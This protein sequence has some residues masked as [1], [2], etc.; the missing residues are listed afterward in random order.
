MSIYITGDCH[1]DYRRF[2]TEIFPEQREMTKDDYVIICGDFGYWSEDKEQLWWLRWLDQ[3]PF[4][5]LWVDG[6][7]E[8]YDLLKTCPVK[9][10]H[11]GKVQEIMPSVIHLMRGQVYEIS[12]CTIF[13][14]GGA[15]SH[16]IQGGIL[17]LDDPEF[18]SR[19]KQLDKGYLPYRINHVSWW[20]EELPSEEECREGLRNIEKCNVTVDYVVTHCA[21]T[22]IQD[23]VGNGLFVPDRLTDYLQ[24]VEERLQYRKWF[25]GH[26]HDNRNVTDRHILLYEQMIRIW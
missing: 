19:K 12:G 17:E 8:N 10:W 16:D 2:N 14:F 3:K 5:T 23:I 21:P 1:G 4:T 26:Y 11:G 9:E 25:F 18:K 6:N 15:Q 24:E 13:T 7:H 22:K 20:K